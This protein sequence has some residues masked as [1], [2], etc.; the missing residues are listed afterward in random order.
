MQAHLGCLPEERRARQE[1]R[2]S[3]EF[4]FE[5]PPT[6]ATSDELQDTVCYAEVSSALKSHIEAR[7]YKLIER[8]AGDAYAIA[9]RIAGENVSLAVV[10]HKVRPPVENLLGG[11]VYRCADFPP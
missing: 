4:R 3:V 2:L 5:T 11:A 8:I 7:E 6:A 1:V 9:K 10:V